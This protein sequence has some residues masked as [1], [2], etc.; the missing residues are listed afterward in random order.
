MG[1][2]RDILQVILSNT[3]VQPFCSRYWVPLSICPCHQWYVAIFI[4]Q[5]TRFIIFIFQMSIISL[6]PCYPA[7]DYS[8]AATVHGVSY[9]CQRD[10]SS[11]H[12]ILW[13]VI[14][15]M[16]VPKIVMMIKRRIKIPICCICVS[17][18][19]PTTLYF[20]IYTLY[21][22]ALYSVVCEWARVRWPNLHFFSKYIVY[23]TGTKAVYWPSSLNTKHY[24][25]LH[26]KVLF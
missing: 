10:Q 24:H 20:T 16:G 5:K 21:W 2:L 12:R 13:L 18:L 23:Y 14:F 15:S 7:Q 6:R 19:K 11:F 3:A 1:K 26:R 9:I 17:Q 25:F 4:D 8:E 22:V